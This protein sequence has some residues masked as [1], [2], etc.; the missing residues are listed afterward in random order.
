M[1][2]ERVQELEL[3]LDREARVTTDLQSFAVTEDQQAVR[4]LA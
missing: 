3:N 2:I 4:E 1:A